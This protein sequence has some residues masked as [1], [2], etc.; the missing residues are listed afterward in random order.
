MTLDR[1]TYLERGVTLTTAAAGMVPLAGCASREEPEPEPQEPGEND[2]PEDPTDEGTLRIATT[3]AFVTDEESASVWLKEAFEDEYDDATVE[4]VL[5]ATGVDHYIE[6]EQRGFLP[7]VDA[8]IGLR[9]AD[10]EAVDEHLEDERLFRTL[11]LDRI[12][13][14][15]N[16]R[17][18]LGIDDPDGRLLPVST[19]YS[20]L[21]CNSEL[22]EVPGDFEDLLD[23]DY[24]DAVITPSPTGGGRGQ[25]L[26]SYLYDREG[27]DGALEQWDALEDNG[28][29]RRASWEEVLTAYQDEERPI[30]VAY[31]G[32]ALAAID[33]KI[34]PDPAAEEREGN[35]TAPPSEP[36]TDPAKA[37][38]ETTTDPLEDDDDGGGSDDN[39]DENGYDEVPEAYQVTYFDGESY[40]EPY[41]MAIFDNAL[42]LD[43]AYSFLE[44]TLTE[45]AQAAIAPRLGQYPARSIDGLEF[46]DDHRAYQEY[47]W[48]PADVSTLD[49]ETRR[50][51]VP[52]LLEA[53]TE[54]FD[55]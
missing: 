20:C 13:N 52:A 17:P 43:L 11:N 28:L 16:V 4:W 32:D 21:L 34:G 25:A 40:A 29:D 18:G 15:A 41:F 30:A 5:P 46:E 49:Y 53:W 45:T 48:E 9:P 50:T 8:Y 3:E 22:T 38:N 14:A 27:T 23:A 31:A 51:D 47:A 10:L 35:E 39:D 26:L 7:E 1:R 24:E 36:D 54:T 19:H 12:D 6:R 2:E 44:F 33:S 42:N 37:D 55:S